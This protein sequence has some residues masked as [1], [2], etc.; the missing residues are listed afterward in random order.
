MLSQS[1]EILHLQQAYGVVTEQV[2][3]PENMAF[4]G[5]VRHSLIYLC[6]CTNVKRRVIVAGESLTCG[7]E[8]LSTTLTWSLCGSAAY[9][10]L[11]LGMVWRVCWGLS[12]FLTVTSCY[13]SIWAP[14]VLPGCAEGTKISHKDKD[15]VCMNCHRGLGQRWGLFLTG[16]CESVAQGT[17]KPEVLVLLVP[18]SSLVRFQWPLF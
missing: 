1:P 12:V 17:G 7:M 8:A 6:F 18:Q 10:V 9:Q 5:S 11:R 4:R 14:L 16:M 3:C 13:I 15:G 2:L